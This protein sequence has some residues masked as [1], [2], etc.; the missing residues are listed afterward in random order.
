MRSIWPTERHGAA[1]IW[2]GRR[3]REFGCL[4]RLAASTAIFTAQ[5]AGNGGGGSMSK[6]E[7]PRNA[8]T[9]IAERARD[10]DRD[11]ILLWIC[12]QRKRVDH[13]PTGTTTATKGFNRPA[14]R[15]T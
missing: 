14:E 1:L 15:A 13:I 9:P 11:D 6:R 3:R 5:G 12:G 2:R 10:C 4:E 8:W 7:L